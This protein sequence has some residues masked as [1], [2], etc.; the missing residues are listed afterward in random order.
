[1]MSNVEYNIIGLKEEGT[2]S[3]SYTSNI[4]II[5]IIH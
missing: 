1:M 4:I 3:S 5:N 2:C